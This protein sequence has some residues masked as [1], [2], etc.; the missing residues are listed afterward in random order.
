MLADAGAQC[1]QRDLDHGVVDVL[2]LELCLLWV[3]NPV[4]HD[5][6]DLD[7]DVVLGDGFLFLDRGHVDAQV[8]RVLPLEERNNPVEAGPAGRVITAEPEDDGA[9]VLIGDAQTCDRDRDQDDGNKRC[10]VEHGSLRWPAG[11][12][13]KIP[14]RTLRQME[15]AGG[16]GDRDFAGPLCYGE[17]AED[18]N[19]HV[20]DP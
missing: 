15:P 2:H 6:I 5:R 12:A 3:D 13:G 18:L 14:P 10:F 4:P 9:R 17:R 7:R 16:S 19:E 1:R 8:D 11:M 20:H